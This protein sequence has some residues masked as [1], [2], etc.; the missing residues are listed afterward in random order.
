MEKISTERLAGWG[1][2]AARSIPIRGA[3]SGRSAARRLR[4]AM[5]AVTDKSRDSREPAWFADNEYLARR[6]AD[7]AIEAFRAAR[8]LRRGPES[9]AIVMLCRALVDAGPVTEERIE[10]FLTGARRA[11]ETPENEAALFGAALRAALID[12]L[13][14][15]E[16]DAARAAELFTGLRTL[17]DMDLTHALEASDPVDAVLRRDGVYP[18]MDE[19][20]RAQYRAQVQALAKERRIPA[21]QMAEEALDRGLHEVLFPPCER[22]GA[23]YIAMRVFFPAALAIL[24]GALAG[25]VCTALLAVWPLS[26]LTRVGLD[27]ALLRLVRPR[28][29]PRLEL[30]D[31]IGPEGRTVCAVSALLS[32]DETG[33]RLVR[34]LEEYRLANRDCGEELLFALLADLPDGMEF[35]PKTWP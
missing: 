30:K 13:A 23:G 25:S 29:L 2:E 34:R 24:I 16:V 32:D 6:E 10:A 33:P 31:G 11:R 21:A 35:P 9:A 14:G 27:S 19:A 12:A 22:T 8:R 20:S 18:A 26:E 7:I 3:V 28:R 15:P 4:R 17:A 1:D 5:E